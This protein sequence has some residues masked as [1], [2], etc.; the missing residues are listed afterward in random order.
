[1]VIH[2]SFL[3]SNTIDCLV[4]LSVDLIYFRFSD[5]FCPFFINNGF[6]SNIVFAVFSFKFLKELPT[7]EGFLSLWS[8]DWTFFRFSRATCA[9]SSIFVLT[10][11]I[12]KF[13]GT[14]AA[15]AEMKKIIYWILGTYS[16]VGLL[17]V[18]V[19]S[20][21]NQQTK[22]IFKIN[23]KNSTAMC[24]MHFRYV[25]VTKER[26][27]FIISLLL[28]KNAIKFLTIQYHHCFRPQL[29]AW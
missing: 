5:L 1:M 20:T 9:I 12:S 21:V 24:K 16:L 4:V 11:V 22:N 8:R 2:L 28:N 14:N 18:K 7:F 15:E 6:I 19:S 29:L 3:G 23:I 25:N 27:H 17:F 26:R 10:A 13:E